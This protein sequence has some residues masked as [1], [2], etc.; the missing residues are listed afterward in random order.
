MIRALTFDQFCARSYRQGRSQPRFAC[1]HNDPQVHAYCE[2]NSAEEAWKRRWRDYAAHLRWTRK[3]DHSAESRRFAGLPAHP[4]LQQT[5]DNAYREA[6]F[7]CRAKGIAD[8]A[9][10]AIAAFQSPDGQ[11]SILSTVAKIGSSTAKR[12]GLMSS[13]AADVGLQ[14][15]VRR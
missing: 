7:L 11:G 5:L 4:V 12:P 15:A 6:F 2:I 13:E 1:L 8:S 3:L 14:V 9:A 10:L